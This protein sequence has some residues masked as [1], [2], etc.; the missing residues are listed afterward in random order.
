LAGPRGKVPVKYRAK[1]L[2]KTVGGQPFGETDLG[3]DLG[4]GRC[5]HL[6][7]FVV[8]KLGW[9]VDRFREWD[10]VDVYIFYIFDVVGFWG[11]I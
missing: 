10:L 5:A 2:A 4:G 9:P 8:H 3:G 7:V 11:R 1:Y 6:R